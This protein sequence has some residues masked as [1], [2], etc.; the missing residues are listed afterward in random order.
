MLKGKKDRTKEQCKV[1]KSCLLAEYFDID[2]ILLKKEGYAFIV[3]S[4]SISAVKDIDK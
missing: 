4:D 3:C 1:N 2:A